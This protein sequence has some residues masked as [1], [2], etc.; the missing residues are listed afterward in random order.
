MMNLLIGVINATTEDISEVI[1]E[2]TVNI[3]ENTASQNAELKTEN[4]ANQNSNV[5]KQYILLGALIV[6]LL[7]ILIIEKLKGFKTIIMFALTVL[8]VY[9]VFINAIV[10][11]QNIILFSAII[12][13]LIIII[14]IIIKDGIQTK[15]FS[16]VLSVLITIIIT[17]L[18][19]FGICKIVDLN[20]LSTNSIKIKEFNNCEN[21]ILGTSMIIF[22]GIYMDIVSRIISSLDETKDK[23]VDIGHRE[24]FKNGMKIGKDFISEKINLIFLFFVGINFV[25]ICNML[26][27]G[28]SILEI[29]DN[30]QFFVSVL[31]TIIGNIGLVLSVPI[32]SYI[33]SMFNGKKTAYKTIS[34]N[35][36][37]GKRSLKL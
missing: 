13:V 5:N 10:N 4:I 25:S 20:N 23:T 21:V 2:E 24:Q 29:I 18:S 6:L 26:K 3:E 31:I 28:Y 33:Y 17:S 8:L 11:N 27:G 7:L 34:D 14:N 1:S 15:S 37:D 30:S 9:F 35:K 19:I 16:E 36:I 22:A 32:T 12:T